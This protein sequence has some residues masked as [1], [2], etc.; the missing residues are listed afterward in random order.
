MNQEVTTHFTPYQKMVMLIL[1]L[2]QFVIILDFMIIAPIGDVLMKTLNISTGQFGLVVSAYAFSAAISG[3]A[4]AGFA[5]RYDR[6]KMLVVFVLGFI[7][8]TLFCGLSNTYAELL[9]ARILTGIFAGVTSST[10][11]TIVADVF[12]ATM[13]GRVMGVVQMGFGLSQVLGIPLGIFI[14]ARFNWHSTFMFIVALTALILIAIAYGFKPINAHLKHQ[15]DKNAFLHLWHTVTNKQYQ[16]GFMATTFLTIGGFM[17]MPFSSIFLVNNVHVTNEQL[18]IVFLFTGLS[19]LVMMPLIGKLSDKFDRFRMFTFASVASAIMVVLYTHLPVMP[20]WSVVIFNMV[21]F[22]AIMSRMSP[23]MALN[24]MV[25][26]PEDR[27]AYMSISASLQQ[28]A[29]GLGAIL[30]GLIVHQSSATSPIE[31]FDVLGY[32]A[33]AIFIFCVYLVSRV[34]IS[35]KQQAA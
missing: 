16:T 25:A 27:G 22:A 7:L 5:D 6:K 35:L 9:A 1:A 15:R 28:T 18:S 29:G 4:I 19:S 13:R 21:F 30:A 12:A 34:D 8:G 2:L 14:A 20:L 23:A 17:L 31:H 10:L 3:I 11:L 32:V 26:K 24:S 33:V